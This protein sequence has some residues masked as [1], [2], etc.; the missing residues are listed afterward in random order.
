MID[1]YG[2]TSSLTEISGFAA[3]KRSRSDCITSPSLPSLYHIIRSSVSAIAALA[4]RAPA[5]VDAASN[6][7]ISSVIV[8]LLWVGFVIHHPAQIDQAGLSKA[9]AH[10]VPE[11]S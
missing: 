5:T 11:P 4:I 7:P 10:P 3:S 2:T 9:H 1:L 8:S 6:F